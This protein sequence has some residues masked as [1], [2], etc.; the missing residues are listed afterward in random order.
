MV[1][2]KSVFSLYGYRGDDD[3]GNLGLDRKLGDDTA[4]FV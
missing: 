4:Q 2:K 1:D 3:E